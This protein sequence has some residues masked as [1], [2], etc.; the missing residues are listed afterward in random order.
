MNKKIYLLPLLLL[1]LVF[2]SCEE[3]KEINR[4]ADWKVRGEMFIDSIAA[5]AAAQTAQ[6][7]DPDKI[8]RVLDP[9]NQAYIYCKKN[10]APEYVA[11][12]PNVSPLYTD[13]VVTFYRMTYF[14]GDLVQEN[15]AGENPSKFDKPATFT[16]DGVISG[17]TWALQTMKQGERWTLY[18]P[19][20]SGYGAG[21]GN[22]NTLQP[23]ST[24]VY[25]VQLLK[26]MPE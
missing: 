22:D 16:V 11:T 10:M 26:V 1:A 21:T 18:I 7:P 23:Y 8:Y 15:F 12:I 20:Q 25:D 14:N 4:Y 5:V 2:A 13:T 3:T 9:T 24:L 17:W 19:W 6:T